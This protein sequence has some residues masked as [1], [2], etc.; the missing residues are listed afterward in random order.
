MG[1]E[2][3][4]PSFVLELLIYWEKMCARIGD[5][6]PYRRNEK[7]CPGLVKLVC[8]AEICDCS[9]K[10][11]ELLVQDEYNTGKDAG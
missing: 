3:T 8:D 9:Q 5:I 4:E 11:I 2:N 6:F 7:S 10:I 1:A